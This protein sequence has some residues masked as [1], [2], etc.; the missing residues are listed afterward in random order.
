MVTDSDNPDNVSVLPLTNYN[1]YEEDGETYLDVTFELSGVEP[2]SG[3]WNGNLQ[4]VDIHKG[5]GVQTLE[6][7]NLF[8][9]FAVNAGIGTSNSASISQVK[10]ISLYYPNLGTITDSE[11]FVVRFCHANT[12]TNPYINIGGNTY[13]NI[14]FYE[15]DGTLSSTKTFD[16][17]I[18]VLKK[19]ANEASLTFYKNCQSY[20]AFMATNATQV[21]HRLR[22]TRGS[23]NYDFNGSSDVDVAIVGSSTT[24]NF[25]VSDTAPSNP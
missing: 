22:L 2:N 17:G 13:S 8:D 9:S 25:T 3:V 7:R 11:W 21:G 10:Y 24:A 16:A 4:F 5:E 1:E 15:S 14:T 6:Y 12:N 18:H 19:N 23:T 20:R